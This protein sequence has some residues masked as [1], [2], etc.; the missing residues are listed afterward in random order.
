[1]MRP[2]TTTRPGVV[3]ALA[4]AVA[5]ASF[6]AFAPVRHS[7]YLQDDRPIVERNPVVARGNW[8][9]IFG[10]DYW[11]GVGG[12]ET[13]L[14]R[15]VTILS[16]AL[17]RGA[18]GPAPPLRAH[19]VNVALHVMASLALGALALR[20]RASRAAAA[21]ASLLFALH[22][23]HV[24]VVAGLVGRAEILALL[25]TIAALL[26]QS[27]AGEWARSGGPPT[28]PGPGR[29]RAASWTAAALLFLALGS[30]ETAFAAPPLLL[31]LEL[32]FRPRPAARLGRWALERA[33]AL[34]P[35]AL[36][37]TVFLALRLR[38]L[39]VF[40]GTQ[41]P[42]L[43]ENPLVALDGMERI[44]TALGIAG[45]AFRL[46]VFP[47][48]LSADYSGNVIRTYP[49]LLAS[50]PLMGLVVLAAFAAVALAPLFLRRASARPLAFASLLFLL[51]YL[52]VGNLLVLVGI[53]FAE[54]LLYLPSAGFCLLAGIVAASLAGI[55]RPGA[56]IAMACGA[57]VVA[58]ALAVRTSVE[59]TAYR[60][61]ETMFAA[62]VRSTP[63]SPRAQF[64]LGKIRLDQGRVDEALR[65]FEETVALWPRFS[66]AWFEKALIELR[67]GDRAAAARSLREAVRANP[68][69]DEAWR[70]LGDLERE[71]GHP[72]E[73][74]IAYRRA[75]RGMG[76]F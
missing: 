48:P 64:T 61:V 45:R 55:A 52:A 24:S 25:F 40:P 5:I 62:A 9:E 15:P 10:T 17:E 73:A 71:A 21:C 69:F 6:A 57:A 49:S 75:A 12:S 26:A 14:Y 20:L 65:L 68:W 37:V 54:R 23:V 39:G 50:L 8:G 22:P 36:A 43:S 66:S 28:S 13:N 35:S 51:P 74:A 38:A 42:R 56:R 67:R 1:M 76:T 60:S 29:S 47:H 3:A 44:A 41:R 7:G 18:G 16:F 31:A 63:Q 59:A 30:K 27:A 33:T 58:V 4:L 11:G 34:A 70:R 2:S 53:G 19:L 32:L 72:A 46:L